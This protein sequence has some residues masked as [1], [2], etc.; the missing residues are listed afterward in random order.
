MLD[1]LGKLDPSS[2]VAPYRQI[3]TCL[4]AVIR[5]AA[6]GTRL[7]SNIELSKHFEVARM[8]IRAAVAELAHDGLVVTRQGSGVFVAGRGGP[9]F[10]EVA[11]AVRDELAGSGQDRLPDVAVIAARHGVSAHV[12]RRAL[13][14]LEA[15]GLDRDVRRKPR[16]ARADA[17]E[18]ALDAAVAAVEAAHASI[19]RQRALNGGQRERV[20]AL[21][22]GLRQVTTSATLARTAASLE[23]AQ[24]HLLAE[25][26]V[27]DAAQL[28]HD[29]LAEANPRRWTH[30]QA[31]AE[32]AADLAVRLPPHEA[33]A[34]RAAAWLHDIGYT[35]DLASS[36]FHPL[37]G[38]R[39][40]STTGTDPRVVALVAHH[41]AAASEATELGLDAEL[42]GYP[43]EQS[44]VRDLLWLCDMT[45]GP[46]GQPM[47]FADRMAEVQ[48]RYG[49]D[50]YVSRALAHGMPARAAAVERAQAWIAARHSSL[51]C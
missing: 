3:A 6:P 50:H 39:F 11:D 30:V 38:A 45:I 28:A 9:G 37:D 33:A 40:L 18:L 15:E 14:V 24:Q 44:I 12:A 21:L 4:Y 49:P 1:L 48:T 8:I 46:D 32:Q 26:A 27:L 41:S 16:R 42:A 10:F 36:G 5:E 35:T 19:P 13:D 34:L 29:Y 47:T 43:D 17:A 22:R 20:A 23:L 25:T 31:V 2:S 7:P 51:P